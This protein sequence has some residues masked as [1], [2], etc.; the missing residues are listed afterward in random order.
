M[1]TRA[2]AFETLVY[3]Y[4]IDPAIRA[5]L[6]TQLLLETLSR[7]I[8]IGSIQ[9]LRTPNPNASIQQERERLEA[10]RIAGV[11]ALRS[12]MSRPLETAVPSAP[13]QADSRPSG[14]Q[15]ALD[16]P[17]FRECAQSTLVTLKAQLQ[18]MQ[19]GQALGYLRSARYTR[20]DGTGETAD[21]L[22][23][24]LR[25]GAVG[26][27]ASELRENIQL[28]LALSSEDPNPRSGLWQAFLA[29]RHPRAPLNPADRRCMEIWLWRLAYERVILGRGL[30][31][32]EQSALA[33]HSTCRGFETYTR[34]QQRL[35]NLRALIPQWP[36]EVSQFAAGKMR[37]A[38]VQ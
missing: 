14:L 30:I 24:G 12:A 16:L 34:E 26:G 15:A 10:I 8:A 32:P 11:T 31:L 33:A 23:C 4:Q 5:H 13:A 35:H 21:G 27:R 25:L 20:G 2:L 29:A 19:S 9:P 18:Q 7:G 38:G 3:Q 17:R 1:S 37:E 22:F 28:L 36:V 6:P